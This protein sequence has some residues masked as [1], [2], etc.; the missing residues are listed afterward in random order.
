MHK[1]RR[2]RPD[3][4]PAVIV[5]FGCTTGIQFRK[6]FE[7]LCPVG[8]FILRESRGF[9]ILLRH[10]HQQ[11]FP[12]HTCRCEWLSA[13]RCWLLTREHILI[14]GGD[15]KFFGGRFSPVSG[16]ESTPYVAFIQAFMNR[17]P[18]VVSSIFMERE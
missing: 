7:R 12:V 14:P 1:H 15:E 2:S 9:A 3:A 10:G 8:D 6:R 4:L 17:Q 11:R 18:S 16:M 5:P 13:A